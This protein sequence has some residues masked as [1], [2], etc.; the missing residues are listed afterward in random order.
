VQECELG[1]V[2]GDRR[3]AGDGRDDK[4]SGERPTRPRTGTADGS[5]LD[6]GL[7]GLGEPDQI[8]QDDRADTPVSKPAGRDPVVDLLHRNVCE[9]RPLGP[10]HPRGPSALADGS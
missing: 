4:A 8:H 9:E 2:Q 5:G 10:R 6:G 3:G 7:N 1:D